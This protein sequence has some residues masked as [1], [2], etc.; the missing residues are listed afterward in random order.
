[1][2]VLK[3]ALRETRS[4]NVREL[5]AASKTASSAAASVSTFERGEIT[6]KP[7]GMATV[8]KNVGGQNH[9]NFSMQAVIVVC[10]AAAASALKIPR[11]GIF[12]SMLGAWMPIGRV[13]VCVVAFSSFNVVDDRSEARDRSNEVQVS[14]KHLTLAHSF[15]QRDEHMLAGAEIGCAGN[16]STLNDGCQYIGLSVES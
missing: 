11:D 15:I 6:S 13:H 10:A 2:S 1:M 5:S 12:S 4:N 3:S 8:C 7:R 14:V 16:F 9:G